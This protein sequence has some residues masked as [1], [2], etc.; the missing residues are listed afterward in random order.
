MV[1]DRRDGTMKIYFDIFLF[2]F[3]WSN[4]CSLY[5]ESGS[6]HTLIVIISNDLQATHNKKKLVGPLLL[7]QNECPLG[8][9]FSSLL[10]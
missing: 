3:K 4:L 2:I 7:K 10:L 8:P 5:P 1:G 9:I 6:I